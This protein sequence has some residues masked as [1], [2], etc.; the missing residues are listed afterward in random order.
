MATH[1]YTN[2][3]SISTAW[4]FKQ[5]MLRGPRPPQQASAPSQPGR[6][7]LPYRD[8]RKPL[9]VTIT[10]S[11]GPEAWWVIQARGREFR[12]PG[13]RCIHDVMAPIN[14]LVFR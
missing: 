4:T 8:A 3:C 14:G 1:T 11:G 9:T 12:V 13:N 2:T 6:K 10:Y 7:L 5:V